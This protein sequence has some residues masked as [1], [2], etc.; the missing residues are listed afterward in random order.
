M[1]YIHIFASSLLP[2]YHRLP[3]TLNKIMPYLIL[4]SCCKYRSIVFTFLLNPAHALHGVVSY[5]HFVCQCVRVSAI[6][7]IFGGGPP[8]TQGRNHSLF[9]KIAPG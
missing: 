6:N 5:F 2:R 7:L 9:K 1:V 4:H 8:L 3:P